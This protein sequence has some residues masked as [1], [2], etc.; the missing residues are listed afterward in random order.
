MCILDLIRF[1]HHLSF[2]VYNIS[3]V[4]KYYKYQLV[5]NIKLFLQMINLTNR[6]TLSRFPNLPPYELWLVSNGS[7]VVQVV[8][9]ACCEE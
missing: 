9:S 5:E 1:F 4:R 6:T 2:N 8:R 7:R 3:N